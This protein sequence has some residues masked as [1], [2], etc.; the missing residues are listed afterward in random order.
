MHYK[1]FTLLS[2][3]KDIIGNVNH[4]TIVSLPYVKVNNDRLQDYERISKRYIMGYEMNFH[5]TGL[6]RMTNVS[7]FFYFII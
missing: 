7:L 3:L 4:V 5:Y 2:F 6:H 1:S